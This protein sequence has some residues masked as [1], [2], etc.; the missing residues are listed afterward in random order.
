MRFPFLLRVWIAIAC[1]T[2]SFLLIDHAKTDKD[3][4]EF[5]KK[6]LTIDGYAHAF[7]IY[8]PQDWNNRKQWPVILFLHGAS[9]RGDDGV[10]PSQASFGGDVLANDAHFPAIVIF[11][12]CPKRHWWTDPEIENMALAELEKT[13]SEFNGDRNRIYIMGLSM[14]GYGTWSFA[15]RHP[16]TFAAMIVV[17][18]GVRTISTPSPVIQLPAVSNE[19]N[20]YADI[21]QKIDTPAWIF[22]GEKD[23]VIPVE[24]SRRMAAELKARGA[25][26]IYTEYP[27]LDHQIWPR[28][29]KEPNLFEWL[30][31]K[32]MPSR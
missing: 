30:F 27:G 28:V 12:Q 20:P 3:G 16:K 29:S 14:G 15:A 4:S 1:I 10:F 19:K 25:E 23:N 32:T 13:V 22:H 31:S 8:V 18:G 9:E 26:V 24:E 2:F 7:R 17:A 6:S 21:A 5:F 11:P